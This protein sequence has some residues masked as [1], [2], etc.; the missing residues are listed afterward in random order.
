[1]C[2]DYDE[3][4]A[5]TT[6]TPRSVWISQKKDD[7]WAKSVDN[8]WTSPSEFLDNWDSHHGQIVIH[9]YPQAKGL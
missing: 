1:M 3:G 5:V 7:I 6:G 9:E 2:V 4:I 8:P